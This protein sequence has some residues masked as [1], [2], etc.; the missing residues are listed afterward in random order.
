MENSLNQKREDTK[1]IHFAMSA[2]RQSIQKNSN[3]PKYVSF[4]QVFCANKDCI[5][6]YFFLGKALFVEYEV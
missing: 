4:I 1:N 6:T 2:T 5:I 3:K